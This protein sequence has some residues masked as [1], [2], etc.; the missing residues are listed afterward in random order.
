MSNIET[1]DKVIEEQ[2]EF[3]RKGNSGCIFAKYAAFNCR[4]HKWK[5]IIIEDVIKDINNTIKKAILNDN[6][7]ILN[8]IFPSVRTTKDLINLI[9]QLKTSNFI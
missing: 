1:V 7:V 6:I 3:Y 2:I 5:N 8:L 9:D 4:M